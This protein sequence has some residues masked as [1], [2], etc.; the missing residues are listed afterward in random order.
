MA[1]KRLR[2]GLQ[3]DYD[4]INK[5]LTEGKERAYTVR[6]TISLPERSMVG[7]ARSALAIMRDSN[8]ASTLFEVQDPDTDHWLVIDGEKL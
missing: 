1:R 5:A 6:W 3:P 7:A 4:M 8:N 2:K